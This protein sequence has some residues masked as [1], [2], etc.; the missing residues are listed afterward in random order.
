[1]LTQSLDSVFG[2]NQIV[3][4]EENWF[5]QLK[6]Y[7]IKGA[8]TWQR[9]LLIKTQQNGAVLSCFLRSNPRYFRGL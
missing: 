8:L 4:L 7:S 6:L 2:S 5:P 9:D 1:M 3:L